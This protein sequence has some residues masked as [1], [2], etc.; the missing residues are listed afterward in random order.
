MQITEGKF[1]AFCNGNSDSPP[2]IDIVDPNKNVDEKDRCIFHAID[3]SSPDF[4][5]LSLLAPL[6]SV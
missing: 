3:A 4:P 2:S 1:Y 6:S 5:Q